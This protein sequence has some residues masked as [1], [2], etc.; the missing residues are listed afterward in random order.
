M[1]LSFMKDIAIMEPIPMKNSLVP[2]VVPMTGRAP[3]RYFSLQ[4][5]KNRYNAG[6]FGAKTN[7]PF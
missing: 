3:D 5:E 1:N 4:K 2:K 7:L 6:F